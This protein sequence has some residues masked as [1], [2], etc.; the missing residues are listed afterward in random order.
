MDHRW[1]A[2][3][4]LMLLAMLSI[5]AIQSVQSVNRTAAPVPVATIEPGIRALPVVLAM[6]REKVEEYL[7][8][9]QELLEH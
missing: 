1:N 8:L 3:S 4:W 7:P 9:I 2:I 5:M 6:G